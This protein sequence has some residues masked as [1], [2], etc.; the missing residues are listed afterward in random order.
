MYLVAAS[1]TIG[2]NMEKACADWNLVC[3]CVVIGEGVG[4]REECGSRVP[5]MIQA[6]ASGIACVQR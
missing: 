4:G 6:Q 5:Y 1:G 2:W 3:V